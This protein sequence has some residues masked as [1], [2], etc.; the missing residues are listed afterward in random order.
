MELEAALHGGNAHATFEEATKGLPQTLLGVVPAGLPYSI[1]QLVEHIR[2]SQWD[3]LESSRNPSHVSPPWPEGYWPKEKEPGT[4]ADWKRSLKQISAD[5]EAFIS[6]LR[7]R[8]EGITEP[9]SHGDGQSLAREAILIIDHTSYHTGEIIV[10]R[11]LLKD[12][13]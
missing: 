1:W 5:R 10:L 4:A 8:G 7:Q 3:I 11:R 6:L 13:K 12:W 2:I 9:L